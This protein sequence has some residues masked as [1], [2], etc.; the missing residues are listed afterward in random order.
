MLGI[1]YFVPAAV[2]LALLVLYREDIGLVAVGIYS[3]LAVVGWIVIMVVLGMPLVVFAAWMALLALVL[4]F[5][6]KMAGLGL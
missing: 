4:F 3:A 5:Q 2:L 1:V 6:V